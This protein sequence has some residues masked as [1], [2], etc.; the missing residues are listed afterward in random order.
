MTLGITNTPMIRG[1]GIAATKRMYSTRLDSYDI[2][3][4]ESGDRNEGWISEQTPSLE[5]LRVQIESK[6]TS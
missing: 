3:L 4:S 2:E 5:A 1:L 6:L